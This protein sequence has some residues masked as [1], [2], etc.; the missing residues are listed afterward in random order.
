MVQLSGQRRRVGS[1]EPPA[2]P[3]ANSTV[4]PVAHLVA[5]Y[6]AFP[7]ERDAQRGDDA[8]RGEE[9]RRCLRSRMNAPGAVRDDG[10]QEAGCGFQIE[11]RLGAE[12]GYYE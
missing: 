2:S 7:G 3:T 5:A 8:H 6:S 12:Q 10:E 1:T 9:H 11:A 4:V